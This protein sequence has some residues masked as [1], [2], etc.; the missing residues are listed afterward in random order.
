[1][2]KYNSHPLRHF[3]VFE[4]HNLRTSMREW[5]THYNQGTTPCELGTRSLGFWQ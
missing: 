2:K 3:E 1:M 4:K 5:V